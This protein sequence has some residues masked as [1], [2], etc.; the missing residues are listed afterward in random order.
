MRF[1]T[2]L[3]ALVV[4]SG[5]TALSSKLDDAATAQNLVNVLAIT[6]QNERHLAEDADLDPSVKTAFRDQN[7]AAVLLAK[8]L[9]GE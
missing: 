9:A 6:A 7:S 1:G 4:L 3:V 5:C 8:K 2:L